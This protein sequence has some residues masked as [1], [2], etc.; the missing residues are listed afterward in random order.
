MPGENLIFAIVS[1]KNS[2]DLL[3]LCILDRIKDL[4]FIIK[5]D[6]SAFI[7]ILLLLSIHAIFTHR[8]GLSSLVLKELL[9]HLLE[10]WVVVLRIERICHLS[11]C[12][13]HRGVTTRVRILIVDIVGLQVVARW[14]LLL[15]LESSIDVFNHRWI[16]AIFVVLN[17]M[18]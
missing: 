14:L 13:V 4:L 2:R 7:R 10:P 6:S 17:C 18:E 5:S 12:N 8:R 15:P 16:V 3:V 1:I 11:V 9:L